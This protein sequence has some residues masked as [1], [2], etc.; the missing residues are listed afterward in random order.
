MTTFPQ[1]KRISFDKGINIIFGPNRSGKTT[2]VNSIRY[3]VF[4]MSL[5][6]IPEGVE[7]QYFSS[8]VNGA[9]RKSL[10]ISI[11][12]DIQSVTTT[13]QRV[14][15]SSGS[16]TIEANTALPLGMNLAKPPKYFQKEKDYDNFLS[17]Q[18]GINSENLS[19]ITDLLFAEEGGRQTFLWTKNLERFVLDL[20]T[21]SDSS[22]KLRKADEDL[23]NAK[24]QSKSL[25]ETKRQVLSQINDKQI[26][27]KLIKND[28]E[29]L[30]KSD[31]GKLIEEHD[32]LVIALQDYRNKIAKNTSTLEQKVNDK[33]A[34]MRQIEAISNKN[35]EIEVAKN[36]LKEDAIN[37]FLNSGDPDEYHLARCIYNDKKCPMCY[38]DMAKQIDGRLQSQKCPLCGEGQIPG[39]KKTIDEVEIR[40]KQIERT[41]QELAKKEMS[42]KEEMDNLEKEIHIIN[43]NLQVSRN[44]EHDTIEKI[45]VSNASGEQLLRK[46]IMVRKLDEI[47]SAIQESLAKEEHLGRDI[48]NEKQ[49]IDILEKVFSDTIQACKTESN[50]L[51]LEVKQRF[52]SFVNLATNGEISATLSQQLVPTLDGRS[53]FHPFVIATSEKILMDYAFRIALLSTIAEKDNKVATLMLETPDEGI[54]EAFV[55]YFAK[56]LAKYSANLSLVITTFNST[57]VEVLLEE[58]D[59]MPKIARKLINL[60]PT[61]GTLTQK[62][63]YEPKLVKYFSEN[64]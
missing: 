63:H 5:C 33:L 13:V 38:T 34:L 10:D 30:E 45:N 11:V 64:Q 56:A 61:E 32:K 55:P 44:I 60:L 29:R 3:G 48:E 40:I 35:H 39:D 49:S 43:E 1:D 9:L 47:E 36:R 24:D 14:I 16:P 37:A 54:D 27:Q 59:S 18:I 51:L 15:F 19:R 62:K 6:H 25:E 50:N 8:R 57:M 4:G 46:Q 58:N 22:F 23:R 53:A 42:L 17:E 12:Y 26:E 52:Q 21:S 41:Q 7:I 20:L 28:L 31:I 2:I